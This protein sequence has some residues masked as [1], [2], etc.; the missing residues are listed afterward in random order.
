MTPTLF[1]HPAA[2]SGC[3]SLPSGDGTLSEV[4]APGSRDGAPTG[5]VL[6]QVA[7]D[8]LPVLWVQDRLT[9]QEAGSPYLPG[10]RHPILRV[11]LSRPRDVLI[12]IEE[13][14]R[15]GALA[16][17]VGE[18]WGEAP[19]LDFT[20][21]RRLAL[22]AEAGGRACWLIRRAAS[23]GLSAARARWRIASLPAPPASDDPSA[24]GD[25]LWRADLFRARAMPPA[26]WVLRYDRTAQRLEAVAESAADMAG[27][28]AGDRA[29]G[30][31]EGAQDAARRAVG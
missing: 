29:G 30:R 22:R 31:A 23:A 26:S 27:G 28:R 3:R 25:P 9:R 8:G 15:C 12:A 6:A 5:F 21:S 7:R 16:A 17:V 14:L 19:A 20:A 18:I 10:L 11:D 13:G 24:P 2:S 4:F 1:P